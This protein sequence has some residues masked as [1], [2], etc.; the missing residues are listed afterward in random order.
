[1]RILN[2][3]ALC[4]VVVYSVITVLNTYL[5]EIERAQSNMV[6]FVLNGFAYLVSAIEIEKDK[7]QH[8]ENTGSNA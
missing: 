5:G 6:I 4:F 1:M 3:I 2:K 7:I 8:H